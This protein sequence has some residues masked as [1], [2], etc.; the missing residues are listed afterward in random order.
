MGYCHI[1][2]SHNDD[3][4]PDCRDAE[5]QEAADRNEIIEELAGLRESTNNPGDYD[6]PHCRLRALKYLASRCPKC[7]GEID[8]Y[9]WQAISEERKRTRERN[10]QARLEAKREWDRKAPERAAAAR[11]A[12]LRRWTAIYFG[13]FLPALSCLTFPL[14]YGPFR[15][16]MIFGLIPF[17]NWWECIDLAFRPLF[18]NAIVHSFEFWLIVG[19]VGLPLLAWKKK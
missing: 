9:F 10:E 13:Y 11:R 19:V 2:G 16:V 1:H 15:A 17:F 3:G 6:C 12:K 8:R 7:H 14:L 4:C 5:K 18:H